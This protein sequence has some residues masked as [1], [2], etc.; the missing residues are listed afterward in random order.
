MK[1]YGIGASQAIDSSGEILMIDG[2]DLS[3]VHAGKAFFNWE[4]SNDGADTCVGSLT[5]AKKIYSEKD[6]ENP[7]QLECWNETL[8]PMIYIEGV[9]FDKEGHVGAICLAAM[10]RSFVAR[11]QKI[12]IGS[13]IEGSTMERGKGEEH[14]VLKRTVA[15]RWAITLRPCNKQCFLKVLADDTADVMKSEIDWDSISHDRAPKHG[16]IEIDDPIEDIYHTINEL[17]KTLTAGSSNVAPSQMVGGSALTRENLVP[18]MQNVGM[19]T[20]LKASFKRWNKKKPLKEHLKSE[21]EDVSEEYIDN[22][23][24]L[25]DELHIKKSEESMHTWQQVWNNM[26][27]FHTG[28]VNEKDAP[29]MHKD[30]QKYEHYKLR[31]IPLSSLHHG[32]DT[33]DKPLDREDEAHAHHY[34]KL[35]TQAPPITLHPKETGYHIVDGRHRARAAYLRGDKDILAYVGTPIQAFTKSESPIRIDQSIGNDRANADQK[36][37]IAGIVVPANG[38]Q[39]IQVMNDYGQ[40]SHIKPSA[41]TESG[42]ETAK[43]AS[44]YY[45]AAKDFFDLGE[46][47]P[48]SAYFAHQ[49]APQEGAP[50]FLATEHVSGKP[51]LMGSLFEDSIGKDKNLMH[52]IALMDTILGNS[53]RN[54]GNIILGDTPKL[55]DNE[56]AFEYKQKPAFHIN[57][58]GADIISEDVRNWLTSKDAKKLAGLLASHR[59]GIDRIKKAIFAL[60]TAQKMNHHPIG[61]ILEN[62]HFVEPSPEVAQ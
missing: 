57:Q 48:V 20:R 7:K 55:I 41:L 50:L 8:L 60:K 27:D 42:G 35:D 31:K 15:R 24:K 32:S 38:G 62:V 22:F 29:H 54:H 59:I 5:F 26:K 58:S 21:L 19:Q 44:A 9:L 2:V 4:H 3:D 51:S 49:T 12:E 17:N 30:A 25:A 18:K 16:F 23:A 14:H 28:S 36:A 34:A 10:F 1:I 52:K 61:T 56:H 13:S 33:P 47:V 53:H 45:A 11:N 40:S 39:N 43:N 37:L 6:C 46:H